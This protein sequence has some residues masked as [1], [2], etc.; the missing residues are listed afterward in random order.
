MYIRTAC[1]CMI[2]YVTS[3]P[4]GRHLK[5]LLANHDGGEGPHV[6]LLIQ[7]GPGICMTCGLAAC[8]EQLHT[9]SATHGSL[10]QYLARR[11]TGFDS[12]FVAA[13]E[14]HISL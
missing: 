11:I 10:I 1:N 3:G 2:L 7:S 5:R 8:R 14:G 9:V 4:P 12:L 13:L 6:Q